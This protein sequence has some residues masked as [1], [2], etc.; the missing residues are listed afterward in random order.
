LS[1]G[2]FAQAVGDKVEAGRT[3]ETPDVRFRGKPDIA[4]RLRHVRLWPILL[5]KSV[6]GFFGQ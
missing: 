4:I 2:C 3:H 5:Q 1:R 6:A